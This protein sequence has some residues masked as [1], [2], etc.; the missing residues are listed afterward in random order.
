MTAGPNSLPFHGA[1][2]RPPA[3]TRGAPHLRAAMSLRRAL[4]IVVLALTPCLVMALYNSGQQANAAMARLGLAGLPGWR[5]A[6][7]GALGIGHDPASLWDSLW[8]GALYL[9]PILA[10]SLAVG[11]FWERLFATLRRRPL[12]DGLIVTAL[13]FTLVLPPAAPLWQVALGMSFGIVIGKEI[14]GGTGKN[15]LNPALVGLAFLYFGYPT[16]MAGHPLWTE[17]AGYRGSAVFGAVAAGGM[18]ALAQAGVTWWRAFLGLTQGT[19]GE[20]STLACLLGGTVLIATR[21]ASWRIVAGVLLGMIG[22]ALAFN[23]LG[24]GAGPIFA[25]PWYWHLTLGGFAFGMV[26]LATDPVSAA[27]TDTGRWVY[28]LLIGVVTVLV[29][30]ANPVHPDGVMLAVLFANISAPLI[31]YLVVWANIR[32]RARRDA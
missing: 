27:M 5:G 22:A 11:A 14:F 17:V 3:V 21:V 25:L 26:F 24:G 30:V 18:E 23:A 28:G 16:E 29:R 19:L 13:V 9:L 10:V 6:V 7:L 15:V 1:P 12:R 20:T 4:G 8:H 31:D 32:R 2:P